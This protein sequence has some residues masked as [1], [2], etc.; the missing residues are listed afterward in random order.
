MGKRRSLADGGMGG[1]DDGRRG[2]FEVGCEM[3]VLMEVGLGFGECF[4]SGLRN[5]RLLS[6]H[7]V[8]RLGVMVGYS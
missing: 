2:A 8:L 5:S 3:K 7:G 1:W 4:L 6:V